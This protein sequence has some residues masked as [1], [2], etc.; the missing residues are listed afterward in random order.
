MKIEGRYGDS[1]LAFVSAYLISQR[2]VIRATIRLYVDTG[3]SVTT[4]NDMDAEKI[5]INYARLP[6]STIPYF[7]IGGGHV[8]PYYVQDCTLIFGNYFDKAITEHL[9]NIVVLKHH[10]FDKEAEVHLPS[11]LGL[12]VLKKYRV[13]FT[14]TKVVLEK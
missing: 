8:E 5:G 1:G 10:D 4:I 12:D 3:A 7:G 2:P 13:R 14:D 9:D 6:R 11:L